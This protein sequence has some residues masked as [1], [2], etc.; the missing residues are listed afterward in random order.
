MAPNTGSA[1]LHVPLDGDRALAR[2]V[3]TATPTRTDETDS[4][5]GRS[6]SVSILPESISAEVVGEPAFLNPWRELDRDAFVIA[7]AMKGTARC[8]ACQTKVAKG[9]LQVRNAVVKSGR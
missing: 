3:T 8:G 7:Y 9:E 5:K 1:V 6:M 4:G 2:R